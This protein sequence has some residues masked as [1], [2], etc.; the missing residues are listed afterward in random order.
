MGSFDRHKAVGG[1]VD[2]VLLRC[3]EWN[4]YLRSA[5]P[6]YPDAEYFQE[7]VTLGEVKAR[8]L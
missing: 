6:T 5:C 8:M 4:R 2:Q 7:S 1:V 3:C